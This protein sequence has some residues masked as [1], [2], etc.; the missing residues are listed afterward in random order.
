M[1]TTI[2]RHNKVLW[3]SLIILCVSCFGIYFS[4]NPAFRSVEENALDIMFQLRSS[5]ESEPVQDVVVVMVDEKAIADDFGYYDP[6]PRRYLARL[7]DT[8][9]A[10]GAQWIAIDIAFYDRLTMLDAA[11]DSLLLESFKKAG[12]VMAVS[13]WHQN[14]EGELYIQNPDSFFLAGLKGVGYANLQVSGGG[15]LATVREVKPIATMPDGQTHLAFSSLLYCLYKG[16]SFDDFIQSI[17]GE[18][19]IPLSKKGS[20]V[21]NYVGPPAEWKKQTD[22]YWIQ[23]K[24]GSIVTYRSSRLTGEASLPTELISGKVVIIGNGSEFVPDRFVTPYYSGSNWMYGA[25][26]HANAFLTMLHKTYIHNGSLILVALII[27]MLTSLMAMVTVRLGF[28]AEIS[29]AVILTLTA[30]TTSYLLFVNKG[31]WLPVMSIALSVWL[32]YFATSIYQA[33]TEERGKK[34]IRN[35]FARYAPPAYVDELVKDPSKLELGGEE[36]EISILFSD[37][38][39]FTSMSENL[40]PKELVELLNEYLGAMTHIIFQQ[41]GTLDKYIGDAIVAV[42]GAPLPQNEHA[43]HACYAALEMQKALAELRQKWS[44]KGLPPVR[45]RIGLNTGK[46]VFG[47]IGSDIRYDYTAIG[48]HMNLSSR[49]EGANKNYG[50]YCMI[51]EFTYNLVRERV[52]VRDLDV[53]VVK[54]KSKPVKVFELIG[55]ANEPL[56]AEQRKLIEMYQEGIK[57]YR[58]RNWQE[59]IIKFEQALTFQHTDE[60]SKVYIRRCK[61]FMANPPNEDWDGTYHMTSK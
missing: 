61:E 39:G 42:F 19:A 37:I 41:G 32:S 51:S 36:K 28:A 2:K 46:V 14:D 15:G 55:R 56:S 48:D 40:S 4:L 20:M 13:I 7:I 38:E 52:I 57:L 33:I 45:N 25:E 50:T 47:N 49:L 24:E 11:G 60:P 5:S 18:A 53:I 10:K 3:V 9:A 34:Q 27:L 17:K 59:A 30:W 1:K 16:M 31:I 6:L 23:T 22:G 54:G 44:Q 43:L 35:M 29:L 58:N 12:N 26:V 21:I 8:L